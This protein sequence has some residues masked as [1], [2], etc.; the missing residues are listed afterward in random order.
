MGSEFGAREY[1]P[2]GCGVLVTLM[3]VTEL[4]TQECLTRAFYPAD[5]RMYGD[6]FDEG[7]KLLHQLI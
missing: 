6:L 1:R 3:A 2:L 4:G 7:K 5:I